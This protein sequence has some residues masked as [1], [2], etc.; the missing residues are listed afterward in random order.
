MFTLINYA[1]AEAANQMPSVQVMVRNVGPVECSWLGNNVDLL[2][3]HIFQFG[4]FARGKL[5]LTF[6]R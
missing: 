4:C 2:T 1:A 3:E 6:S 5:L